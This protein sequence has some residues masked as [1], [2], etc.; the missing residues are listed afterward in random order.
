MAAGGLL[1]VE[2]PMSNKLIDTHFRNRL[3]EAGYGKAEFLYSFGYVQ[4]DHVRLKGAPDLKALAERLMMSSE[5]AGVKRAIAKGAKLELGLRGFNRDVLEVHRTNWGSGLTQYEIDMFAAF[6]DAIKV[7]A[8]GLCDDLLQEGYKLLK[9]GYVEDDIELIRS[10]STR[11]YTLKVFKVRNQHYFGMYDE[12]DIAA[13]LE[14][15]RHYFG[16]KVEVVART[17]PNLLLGR[18]L[19]VPVMADV[20]N[21]DPTYDGIRMELISEAI[22]DAREALTALRAA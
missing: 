11:K 17:R 6:M 14:G 2:A 9:A 7:D 22:N 4:G 5:K 3:E 10:F 1:Y 21:P 19:S 18:S 8:A 12:S 20:D 15:K 16:L 13:F